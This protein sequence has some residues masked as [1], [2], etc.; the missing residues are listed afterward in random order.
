MGEKKIFDNVVFTLDPALGFLQRSKLMTDLVDNGAKLWNG[1][2]AEHNVSRPTHTI[3][4]RA[5]KTH[6][7]CIVTPDWVEAGIRNGFTHETK[8]YFPDA[9]KFLTGVVVASTN[10]PQRDREAIF[11]ATVALG[12]QYRKSLTSDVTHLV[13]LAPN[14]DVYKKA[15]ETMAGKVKVI[16]PHWFD[17]CFK[18]SRLVKEDMFL[19]PNPP[20]LQ[21]HL[22]HENGE[23]TL[24]LTNNNAPP[25][26]RFGPDVCALPK[27]EYIQSLTPDKHLFDETL[28]Y[29]HT[30]VALSHSMRISLSSQ[31]E[32]AGATLTTNYTVA[33]SSTKR[34]TIYIFKFRYGDQY[35]TAAKEGHMVASPDWLINTI[36]RGHIESPLRSL[37]DF[38]APRGRIPGM[39]NKVATITGYE[40]G[41]RALIFSLCN[42]VGLRWTVNLENNTTLIICSKRGNDKYK[43]GRLRN[44]D[45]VNHLWLEDCYQYWEFKSMA[46]ER[47]TVFPD[48]N[49]LQ[50]LVGKT[51]LLRTEVE[52]WNNKD[53]R[54]H[55]H[56][57]LPPHLIAGPFLTPEQ[58]SSP[59]MTRSRQHPSG[60]VQGDTDDRTRSK[61]DLQRLDTT[62]S[63]RAD[64][65]EASNE[66]TDQEKDKESDKNGSPGGTMQTS[67]TATGKQRNSA[68]SGLRSKRPRLETSKTLLEQPSQSTDESSLEHISQP[69]STPEVSSES[70]SS[71]KKQPTPSL[72]R[73]RN[74][75]TSMDLNDPDTVNTTTSPTPGDSTEKIT[76]NDEMDEE[77]GPSVG[78][79]LSF[80]ESPT[81]ITTTSCTLTK[82][83]EKSI[84]K[85]GSAIVSEITKADILIVNDRILRTPKFLCA[86]NLGT[87]IVTKQW[88]T[89]SIAKQTWCSPSDY[90]VHDKEMEG[91]YGFTLH[92][93]LL[94]AQQGIQAEGKRVHGTW[95]QG[96]EVCVLQ[97]SSGQ[98]LKQV[99]ETAGGKY[100]QVPKR[101]AL[102]LKKKDGI[103]L[104]A[105]TNK[106]DNKHRGWNDLQEHGFSIY[107]Q[108]LVI[109]GSLRQ[110]LVLDSFKLA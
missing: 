75:L 82:T 89:D 34:L 53:T 9:F 66:T 81:T 69:S 4:N 80:V 106:E 91:N 73:K 25:W 21:P 100:I 63:T 18:L 37:Y 47:Y 98:M 46:I 12:G 28:I 19:F 8:Y 55:M 64:K 32:A 77:R 108:E 72:K 74:E 107:D 20:L 2:Q 50:D 26:P 71:S 90:Q 83:E 68:V 54:P 24:T 88:L 30:D 22:G 5:V 101:H 62:S 15:T 84:K 41:A 42:F 61:M 96:Y 29:L 67:S 97:A 78:N 92:T 11:G 13:C 76:A 85:L 105:L 33:I 3:A 99:V 86:V 39:E 51:P 27:P 94:R 65:T 45:I 87:T 35:M 49:I 93:S 43:V 79:T 52:R 60:S 58:K 14:G 109:I 31:L 103:K 38:P 10:I 56:N 57:Y 70:V 102:G 59:G 44:C 1:E 104:L 48:N 23:G 95:L 40:A 17:N 110:E 7:G 36:Y 6:A 16:L